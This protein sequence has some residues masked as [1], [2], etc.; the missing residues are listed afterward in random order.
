MCTRTT[1]F[2]LF[3]SVAWGEFSDVTDLHFDPREIIVNSHAYVERTFSLSKEIQNQVEEAADQLWH[4][5]QSKKRISKTLYRY[6]L[7]KYGPY[8]FVPLTELL[9]NSMVHTI[10]RSKGEEMP[11]GDPPPSLEIYFQLSANNELILTGLST[12]ALSTFGRFTYLLDETRIDTMKDFIKN[13]EELYP[14]ILFVETSFIPEKAPSLAYYTPL[15]KTQFNDIDLDEILIGANADHLYAFSNKRNQELSFVPATSLNLELA[16]IAIQLLITIS[17]S[18]YGHLDFLPKLPVENHM[19]NHA[20]EF[21]VPLI[22]K[23]PS[24]PK[25]I[26]YPLTKQYSLQERIGTDWFYV[27]LYLQQECADDFLKQLDFPTPWFYVRYKDARFHLRLRVRS[28]FLHWVNTLLLEKQIEDY[29][30]CPYEREIERY[31]CMEA[32]EQIFHQDSLACIHLLKH[33]KELDLPL[34]VLGAYGILHYLRFYKGPNL[35]D[36]VKVRGIRGLKYEPNAILEAAYAHIDF[37]DYKPSFTAMDSLIHMHCN[38]LG[39]S[40]KMELKA[41]AIA[42]YFL[43]K[44]FPVHCPNQDAADA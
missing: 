26:H 41:R 24:P 7:E 29:S 36:S 37:G 43:K 32:A 19:S 20:V 2:G 14:H 21:V 23:T 3:T 1:P 12:Q 17:R 11:Q 30:I 33:K 39:L 9:D 10:L 42:N 31:K 8:R 13:E 27:K 28:S 6:F 35:F 5:T 34:P 44:R 4:A 15:R 40:P 18:R 38:R 22:R 25:Q 16:P